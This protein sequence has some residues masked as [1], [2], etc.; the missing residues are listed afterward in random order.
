M[1]LPIY[2]YDGKYVL[3]KEDYGNAKSGYEIPR[4]RVGVFKHKELHALALRSREPYGKGKYLSAFARLRIIPH[5]QEGQEGDKVQFVV[6]GKPFLTV[7]TKNIC[8]LEIDTRDVRSIFSY[9]LENYIPF[10]IYRHRTGIY[11]IAHKLTTYKLLELEDKENLNWDTWRSIMRKSQVIEKGIQY[12]LLTGEILN[13]STTSEPSKC[14][15]DK[16]KR[17]SWRRKITAFK[18]HLRTRARLG[19]IDEMISKINSI[20]RESIYNM[21]RTRGK[22]LGSWSVDEDEKLGWARKENYKLHRLIGLKWDNEENLKMLCKHIDNN[23]LSHPIFYPLCIVIDK[24]KDIS[25]NPSG[26]VSTEVAIDKL[27]NM[28]SIPL[29]RAYGVILK[30]ANVGK[31]LDSNSEILQKLNSKLWFSFDIPLKDV[32]SVLNNIQEESK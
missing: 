32:Y 27:F 11:R 10:Q 29:R 7:D 26:P 16:D 3:N 5:A 25:W 9:T 23:D 31:G 30:E 14:V 6:Y 22:L 8:T 28:L 19:A 21:L 4:T 18:K 12:N 17:K 24:L 20:P 2:W 1:T 13:P 15:E